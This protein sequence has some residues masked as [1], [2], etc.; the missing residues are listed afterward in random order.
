MRKGTACTIIAALTGLTA[1]VAEARVSQS[2][3]AKEVANAFMTKKDLRKPGADADFIIVPPQGNP[4]GF[5]DRKI[6]KFPTRGSHFAVLSSGNAKAATRK[7]KS[8]SLSYNNRGPVVRGTRDAVMLR[9]KFRVPKGR[10]CLS[11]EFKFLSEE[12]PEF[13][14]SEFNDAFIAELDGTT[15]DSERNDPVIESPRNFAKDSN[16]NPIRVN[17]VGN[18]AVK[19]RHARG[20]TYDAATRALRAQRRVKPGMHTLYLSIFDQ[21]DRQYDSAVFVDGLK[22]R[23]RAS[24][25]TGVVVP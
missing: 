5:S 9:V 17:T 21:G 20:T 13:V 1:V 6:A 24:C 8:D 18:A 25:K 4:A 7:N 12:F 10:N 19:A 23:N 11:F 3:D 2:R 15:W 16:G 14:N 22:F